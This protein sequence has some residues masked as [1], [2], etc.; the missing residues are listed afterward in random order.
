MLYEGCK[1]GI[2]I[3]E[4]LKSHVGRIADYG[5]MT[6]IPDLKIIFTGN[7]QGLGGVIGLRVE[8]QNARVYFRGVEFY[9]RINR[10]R[11]LEECP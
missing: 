9:P 5:L 7:M 11:A 8:L 10:L 6:L 1:H 2:A 3:F 4:Q